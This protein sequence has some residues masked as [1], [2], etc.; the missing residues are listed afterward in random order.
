MALRKLIC[1]ERAAVPNRRLM[2]VNIWALP[3]VPIW[4]SCCRFRPTAPCVTVQCKP[5]LIKFTRSQERKQ[6]HHKAHVVCTQRLHRLT[7]LVTFP[8]MNRPEAWNDT[9]LLDDEPFCTEFYVRSTADAETLSRRSTREHND[10]ARHENIVKQLQ[11]Q[12]DAV[13]PV[14]ALVPCLCH[15]TKERE[16]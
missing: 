4:L 6:V 5:P 15:L 1:L 3:C 9:S 7:P 8:R 16:G 13:R 10:R 11:E 12:Q 2:S 14:L